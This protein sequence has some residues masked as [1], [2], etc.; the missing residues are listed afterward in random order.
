LTAPARRCIR[1]GISNGGKEGGGE[2]QSGRIASRDAIRREFNFHVEANLLNHRS[3]SYIRRGSSPPTSPPP[4]L[5]ASRL[6]P[7]ADGSRSDVPFKFRRDSTGRRK[8]V[9]VA[10]L[11]RSRRRFI[12]S[13]D[14]APLSRYRGWHPRARKYIVELSSSVGHRV[15]WRGVSQRARVRRKVQRFNASSIFVKRLII[16]VIPVVVV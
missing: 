15:A 10:S 6:D 11:S 2:K 4:A 5:L 7:S 13:L 14:L 16:V 8:R 9:R 12:P 3:R 1:G